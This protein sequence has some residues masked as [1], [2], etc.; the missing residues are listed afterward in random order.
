MPWT[1]LLPLAPI[2]SAKS[3]LRPASGTA[4]DHEALVIALRTDTA[5][6]LRASQS[7]HR[8]L[9]ISPDPRCLAWAADLEFETLAETESGLNGAL[10]QAAE[11]AAAHWPADGVVAVVGDLPAAT[12]LAL[13]AALDALGDAPRGMVADH[14]GTGTTMLSARPGRPLNPQFGPGSAERHAE[15]GAVSLPAAEGLRWDVDTAEDLAE[16]LRLAG[17]EA[18]ATGRLRIVSLGPDATSPTRAPR[19]QD[20]SC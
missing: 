20:R 17:I 1:A 6:A 11:H 18:T 15:S 8:V 13:D 2:R 9:V 12:G 19:Q 10:R 4:A 7:I 5:R 3:R 14:S 16:V